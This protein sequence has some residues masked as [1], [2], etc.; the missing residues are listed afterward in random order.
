MTIAALMLTQ[1]YHKT[2]ASNNPYAVLDDEGDSPS[3]ISDTES[4]ESTMSQAINTNDGTVDVTANDN[5]TQVTNSIGA[6]PSRNDN[7]SSRRRQQQRGKANAFS[8]QAVQEND[9]T[10]HDVHNHKHV[11]NSAI[12]QPVAGLFGVI[13]VPWIILWVFVTGIVVPFFTVIYNSTQCVAW[14]FLFSLL[15]LLKLSNTIPMAATQ[16][17]TPKKEPEPHTQSIFQ[18][19]TSSQ[20][21]NIIVH[22]E[23]AVSTGADKTGMIKFVYGLRNMYQPGII[24]TLVKI[25][26]LSLLG[27]LCFGSFGVSTLFFIAQ[28]FE[29]SKS[30]RET[31]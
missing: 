10:D 27:A 6:R 1:T 22:R 13:A 16:A 25:I 19:T 3:T 20:K 15:R 17:E 4:E 26:Y 21:Y 29:Y 31:A 9:A 18:A 5:E 7:N 12:L 2:M 14:S 23:Y 24:L 30:S 8:A 11:I 28:V